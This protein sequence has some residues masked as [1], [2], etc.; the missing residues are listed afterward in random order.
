[1]VS[2]GGNTKVKLLF[3]IAL[4]FKKNKQK[5]HKMLKGH[6]R[7]TPSLLFQTP[8]QNLVAS[9]PAFQSWGTSSLAYHV[10]FYPVQSL[11]L[12]ASFLLHCSAAIT[13]RSCNLGFCTICDVYKRISCLCCLFNGKN[14]L[15]IEPISSP[16]LTNSFMLSDYGKSFSHLKK[17]NYVLMNGCLATS[18]YLCSL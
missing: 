13:P 9:R 8:T 16:L 4:F 10:V 1:M 3:H 6:Y 11:T 2:K 17:L 14:Y 12:A 5:A 7:F 18:D 15:L